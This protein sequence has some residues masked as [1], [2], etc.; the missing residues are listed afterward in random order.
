LRRPLLFGVIFGLTTFLSININAQTGD[1]AGMAPG[2][3]LRWNVLAE[4]EQ[5]IVDRLAANFY[6]ATLR[7]AQSSAIED[8]TAAI[9]AAGD[10]RARAKFAKQRRAQWRTMSDAQRLALR[11]VKTPNFDNL[12]EQQKLPFRRHA[13]DTLDAKGAINEGAL[14]AALRSEV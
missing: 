5:A 14:A 8:R 6:E 2:A 1:S 11:N 3:D 7:H 13:L 9:Y 4:D 10:A 12:A